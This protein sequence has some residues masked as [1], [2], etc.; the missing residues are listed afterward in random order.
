MK[1]GQSAGNIAVLVLLIALFIT[2][3]VLLIPQEDREKLLN[4][5]NETSDTIK[6]SETDILISENVGLLKPLETDVVKHDI[7]SVSLFFRNE[8]RTIDLSNFLNI[9]KSA[10]GESFQNLVF[11]VDDTINLRDITLFF[12]VQESKGNLIIVLNGQEIYSNKADGLQSIILPKNLIM[13]AN[14]LRFMVSSPGMNIFG[15]NRYRLSDVKLRESFEITNN[16]AIRNVILS[17]TEDGDAKLNYMTFCNKL[18]T[19]ARLRIFINKKEKSNELLPCVPQRKNLE[20]KKTDLV[21]GENEL[22]FDIDKGDYLLN[23]ITL[24]VKSGEGGNE[25]IKF[26]VS[27][28]QYDK[29]LEGE[30]I[31]KIEFGFNQDEKKRAVVNINNNEFSFNTDDE[32][33]ERLVTKFI[34]KGNNFIEIKPENEFEIESLEI[35]IEA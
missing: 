23:D 8:P 34:R 29:I 4:D 19:G 27:Q 21:K 26:V 31:L 3:Y 24:E 35:R 12:F 33:F 5:S 25:K 14:E 16:Q 6:S 11:N 9:E 30:A 22:L 17:S 10:F 15:K 13:S 28:G 1:K 32:K 7:D 18:I 20:I 2:L